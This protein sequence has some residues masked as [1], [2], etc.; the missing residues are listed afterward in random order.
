MPFNYQK[1]VNPVIAKPLL[2]TR[3]IFTP[4]QKNAFSPSKRWF[5]DGIQPPPREAGVAR[6]GMNVRGNDSDDA[7]LAASCMDRG[8]RRVSVDRGLKRFIALDLLLL[9]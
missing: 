1:T 4:T 8:L 3:T 7:L 2:K 6:Y 5:L 9:A